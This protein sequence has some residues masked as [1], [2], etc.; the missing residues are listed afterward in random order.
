[1]TRIL[2]RPD[3]PLDEWV[4]TDLAGFAGVGPVRVGNQ[5]AEQFQHDAYGSV[6]LAAA[7]MFID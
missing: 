7:Q 5:A 2:E 4:A 3:H 6:I 1:M